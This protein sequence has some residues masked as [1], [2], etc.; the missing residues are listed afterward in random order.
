MALS[1]GRDIDMSV[2]WEL[3]HNEMDSEAVISR[4]TVAGGI[5]L[6]RGEM[7]RWWKMYTRRVKG[8]VRMGLAQ[9]TSS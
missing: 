6:K 8:S 7:R 3:R 5:V 4:S 9:S 1:E 2:V